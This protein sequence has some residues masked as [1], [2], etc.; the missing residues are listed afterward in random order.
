L[1]GTGLGAGRPDLVPLANADFIAAGI[2]EELGM[3]G[4][5]A[6][7]V[8]YL[9]LIMRGFKAA[10]V[11]RDPFGTLLATGLSVTIGLQV[12]IVV[13]GVS[14]LIPETGLTTPFLSYGGSSLLA[15]YI[16]I[17]LLLIISEAARRPPAE[18]AT[19]PAPLAQASTEIVTRSPMN[20][21]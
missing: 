18:R 1:G 13:G 12:F 15:N 11:C 4:L 14:N 17:A 8:L 2:G 7:L 21:P 3:I 6:V 5:S 19:T 10:L 16:L 20:P 9:V